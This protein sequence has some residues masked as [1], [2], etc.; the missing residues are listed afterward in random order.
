MCIIRFR[1]VREQKYD[2]HLADSIYSFLQA[3]DKKK[4]VHAYRDDSTNKTAVLFDDGTTQRK[5]VLLEDET[6]DS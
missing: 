4:V 1:L 2:R 5:I 3:E 6:L